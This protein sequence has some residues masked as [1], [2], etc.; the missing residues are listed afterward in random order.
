MFFLAF[1][2]SSAYLLL[3]SGFLSIRNIEV[4][5][6]ERID[7]GLIEDE[8]RSRFSGRFFG[9]VPKNNIIFAFDGPI[10]KAIG[11]RYR[12]IESMETSRK[13]PDTLEARISE[14]HMRAILCSAGR[15]YYADEKGD[16]FPT[17]EFSSQEID[18]DAY[19]VLNDMSSKEIDVSKDAIDPEYL[20]FIA[21]VR[22]MIPGR[23]GVDPERIMETPSRVSSDLRV[24]TS[25]GWQILLNREID[26]DK[27]MSMLD[28]VLREKIG[29]QRSNLDYVDIRADNK[30]FYRFKDGSVGQGGDQEQDGSQ[31]SGSS[32]ES[33]DSKKKKK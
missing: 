19:P 33:V 18:E 15:C 26:A 2:G 20:D 24:R 8:V 29:D 30:V 21:S 16:L 13:F 7:A 1:A 32:S 12:L 9:L 23:I 10:E 27:E 3:F 31:S 6:T 25:E 28:L 22:S 14:R 17:D 4:S 5:G 11:E